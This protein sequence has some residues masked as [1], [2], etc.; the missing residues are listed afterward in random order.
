[1]SDE[2]KTPTPVLKSVRVWQQERGTK[3]DIICLAATASGWDPFQEENTTS[4]TF[5]TEEQY[6]AAL[7]TAK[8][9]LATV[10]NTPGVKRPK[11]LCHPTMLQ[12]VIVKK[13]GLSVLDNV[14]N[15]LA[16]DEASVDEKAALMRSLFTDN[17]LWPK[18]GTTE[19]SLIFEDTPLAFGQVYPM[20]YQTLCGLDRNAGKRVG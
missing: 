10:Q 11:I 20:L 2:T 18:N 14:F 1:M 12:A 16:D 15:K 8:V 9:V 6:E 17:V 19:M 7:E 5:L 3:R 4:E 13:A